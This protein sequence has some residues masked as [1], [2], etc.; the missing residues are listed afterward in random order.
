MMISICLAFRAL[1]LSLFFYSSFAEPTVRRVFELSG[2]HPA[3]DSYTFIKVSVA[4]TYFSVMG[5]SER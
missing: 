3:P 1:K 4:L 5:A 2:R